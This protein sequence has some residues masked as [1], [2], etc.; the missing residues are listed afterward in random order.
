MKHFRLTFLIIF[1]LFL[2]SGISS[3][4]GT[5]AITG[6]DALTAPANDDE[7][8][9]RDTS[10]SADKRIDL[11]L[12][13]ALPFQ[14]FT[15]D[16]ATPSVATG[17]N[18]KTNDD[19]AL[20]ITDFDGGTEGQVIIILGAD[21]GASTIKHDATKINLAGGAD[22]NPA[23]GDILILIYDGTDWDEISRSDNTP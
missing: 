3:A 7:A 2:L 18:W 13:P 23:D 17:N 12:L 15:A 20:N 19:D 9:V 6:H 4:T 16:D 5:K 1:C 14:S 21:S 11:F 8:I 22:C 10:T